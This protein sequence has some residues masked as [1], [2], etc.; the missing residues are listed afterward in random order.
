MARLFACVTR[1]GLPQKLRRVLLGHSLAW[2]ALYVRTELAGELA[3]QV[4]THGLYSVVSLWKKNHPHREPDSTG[5][6]IP[7]VHRARED[8]LFARAIGS[9]RYVVSARTPLLPLYHLLTSTGLNSPQTVVG[10]QQG[11]LHRTAYSPGRYFFMGH[12]PLFLEHPDQLPFV[13]GLGC[14]LLLSHLRA[15]L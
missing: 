10:L 1:A 11:T 4:S 3:F 7:P 2:S 5:T 14:F 6:S 9:T 12:L 13:E 15:H 8:D